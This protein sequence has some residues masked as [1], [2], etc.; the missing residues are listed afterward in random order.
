MSQKGPTPF[1]KIFEGC[2]LREQRTERKRK[3]KKEKEE[4][5]TEKTIIQCPTQE[6]YK[7]NVRLWDSGGCLKVHSRMARG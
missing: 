1:P 6:A 2:A 4:T 5:N 3:E 7:K